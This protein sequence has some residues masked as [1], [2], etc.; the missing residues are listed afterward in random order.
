MTD[1]Q[2]PSTPDAESQREAASRLVDGAQA[3]SE[4][5][6]QAAELL[7]QLAD[8]DARRSLLLRLRVERLHARLDAEELAAFPDQFR[9]DGLPAPTSDDSDGAPKAGASSLLESLGISGGGTRGGVFLSEF[10]SGYMRE[11]EAETEAFRVDRAM[12]HMA[13]VRHA[14]KLAKDDLTIGERSWAE[15]RHELEACVR[16][17]RARAK[18][19][20]RRFATVEDCGN[21][22]V[23]TSC[24]GCGATHDLPSRCSVGR[25]CLACRSAQRSARIARLDVAQTRV[26]RAARRAGL[27]SKRRHGGAWSEKFITL[28]VPHFDLESSD[29][30]I[31][32]RV[33]VVMRAWSR[34]RRSLR[35]WCEAH[36][37]RMPRSTRE[38]ARGLLSFYRGF[39]WTPGADERGHPHFHLWFFGPFLPKELVAAWWSDALVRAGMP[40]DA[41]PRS[42]VLRHRAST[43]CVGARAEGFDT[44]E[45][46]A[47]NLRHALERAARSS[48]DDDAGHVFAARLARVKR[49]RCLRVSDRRRH[50]VAFRVCALGP[51]SAYGVPMDAVRVDIR[52]ATRGNAGEIA[53]G[54]LRVAGSDIV[55]YVE[56][57]SL[58]DVS[59]DGT[60][61]AARTLARL[62]EVLDRRRLTATSK[63]LLQRQEEGC[64]SCG[65]VRTVHVEIVDPRLQQRRAAT[66]STGPPSPAR[67][68][69]GSK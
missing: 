40:A 47:R 1:S 13:T 20:L 11:V 2:T 66:P 48:F 56:G 25:L 12:S 14:F 23:L 22:R 37:S 36:E 65:R 26:V 3:R 16:W 32:A 52:A 4:R 18:G 57:W 45:R 55:R 6:G 53:K 9:G 44:G 46:C 34:F 68:S 27:T 64:G 39:E 42:N 54:A 58:V 38:R 41:V 31:R 50:D 51:C 24:S 49:A 17:H 60:R 5:V 33:E 7:R 35:A 62:Y 19:A 21:A 30:T 8:P 59:G 61:I 10:S 69:N 63:G 43:V 28:T 29:A 15:T 67:A